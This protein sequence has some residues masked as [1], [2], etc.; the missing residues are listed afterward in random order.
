MR[1]AMSSTGM[2]VRKGDSVIITDTAMRRFAG[3]VEKV[4]PSDESASCQLYQ[5]RCH[6]GRLRV[7][8]ADQIE[9]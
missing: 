7:V 1:Q 3:T 6:D 4:G 9:A 8:T 5:I 2:P